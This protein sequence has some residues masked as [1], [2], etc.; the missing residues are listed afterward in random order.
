MKQFKIILTSIILIITSCNYTPSFDMNDIHYKLH[1]YI[2]NPE[3]LI[4]ETNPIMIVDHYDT[5]YNDNKD[6]LIYAISKNGM[7]KRRSMTINEFYNDLKQFTID[8]KYREKIV[9]QTIDGVL[10]SVLLFGPALSLNV[11]GIEIPKNIVKFGNSSNKILLNLNIK[12]KS[13]TFKLIEGNKKYGFKHIL[14]RHSPKMYIKNGKIPSLNTH[15]FVNGERKYIKE[16]LRKF[17]RSNFTKS[18]LELS[19]KTNIIYESELTCLTGM[20]RKYILIVNKNTNN[21]ISFFPENILNIEDIIQLNDL[22][23]KN[24]IEV[25]NKINYN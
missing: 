15:L 24:Y 20:K 3:L 8:S 23:F 13:L 18:N 5:I 19:N 17:S 1:Q 2:M 22:R 14:N 6:T 11:K 21:I 7:I 16:L 25:K 9:Y 4:A 10:Y 12:R